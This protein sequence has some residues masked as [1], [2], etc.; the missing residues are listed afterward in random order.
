MPLEW[1]PPPW[2][3]AADRPKRKQLIAVKLHTNF[4]GE[5]TALE[6]VE[7]GPAQRRG[8][9][10]PRAPCAV[11]RA[12]CGSVRRL[13]ACVEGAGRWRWRASRGVTTENGR[14]GVWTVEVGGSE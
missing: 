13:R 2:M 6:S 14:V 5:N 12:P 9:R 11:R 8:G 1:H 10:Y 3:Q 4:K 7:R